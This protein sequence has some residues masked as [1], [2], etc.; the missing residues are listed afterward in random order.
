MFKLVSK[1]AVMPRSL[2]ITDVE[3]DP[4]AIAVGG[5]GKVFKGKCG[6]QLVALKM[7]YHGHHHDPGVREVPLVCPT[8]C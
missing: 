6:G 3:K 8:Q 2:S 7:L 1:T 5:F 4:Q